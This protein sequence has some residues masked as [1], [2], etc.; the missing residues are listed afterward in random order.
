MQI[1]A[2]LLSRFRFMV[3][4]IF[5]PILFFRFFCEKRLTIPQFHHDIF[6]RKYGIC[7]TVFSDIT[8]TF[9]K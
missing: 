3:K 9:K 4:R 6:G 2:R 5:T 8:P 7:A 1:F